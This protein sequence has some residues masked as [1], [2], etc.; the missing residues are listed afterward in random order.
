MA[1]PRELG[2]TGRD[3]R[4]DALPRVLQTDGGI[5]LSK[6]YYDENDHIG[7]REPPGRFPYTRGISADGYREQLWHM[8]LYAGF[9]SSEESRSR[10]EELL[11]SGASG[12]NIALD[13]P[14]QLGLDSDDPEAEGEVGRVGL[15]VD[16]VA[17]LEHLF[18]GID[19]AEAGTLFT[20]ANGIGPVAA[21]MFIVA[22]RRQGVGEE[23]FVLHLQNDPLKEWTGR[24]AFVLPLVPS[25]KLASDV[26]EYAARRRLYHW[27]PIG[28]C[29]SQYR[30]GGG[31]AV[32]EIAYAVGSARVYVAE[33]AQRG[34]H[35]DEFAPLFELHLSADI[36]LFEEVAKFRAARRV[37]AETMRSCGASSP[38]A[39]Q[40]RVS[41]YT[42]GWR[43]TAKE[44]LNNS[45]RITL[46][47]LAAVLGG[48]QHIGTL[49]IDE[50][51]STPARESALLAT[52]TQQ[53]LAYEGKVGDVS[54]PLGGSHLVEWLTDQLE[55]RI[56]KE[57]EWV[58]EFGGALQAIRTGALQKR[59]QER[60][61]QYQLDI[62]N[63]NRIVVGV[64]AFTAED[65]DRTSIKPFLI[66]ERSERLQQ[67]RLAATKR[68]R[69]GSE[70]RRALAELGE[71][72]QEE[73]VNLMEPIIAAVAAYCTVGEIC[74]T[75]RDVFGDWRQ[76]GISI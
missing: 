2:T 71:A 33:L 28:I 3:G 23:Q 29:G 59:I 52:R 63:R 50:A 32:E 24:G 21:A 38:A 39:T 42:G 10:F 54:D 35:I 74:T 43:L 18:E 14:T 37:W 65:G 62:E 8:D 30:W 68:R 76:E 48:V 53:I 67:E 60:A 11:A 34:L 1:A 51:L 31:T 22:A 44:P 6:P 58:Q 66:D 20:V 17:D 19:I 7:T 4:A 49:S 73:S 16:T 69:S 41:L 36:E 26:V 56:I 47:A 15:A 13:L 40:L 12:V 25:V 46:Q 27:K 75:L 9:G 64:N 70:A 5:A 72:A 45:V 61:Y 55:E 57:L